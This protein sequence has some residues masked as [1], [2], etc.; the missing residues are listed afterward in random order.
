[1]GLPRELRTR[2]N[3]RRIYCKDRNGATLPTLCSGPRPFSPPEHAVV[4]AGL[5]TS[6]GPFFRAGVE[7]SYDP[8][9]VYLTG[10]GNK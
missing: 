3:M 2:H 8:R 9:G 7:L 5:V 1:M 10:K 6:P 4:R